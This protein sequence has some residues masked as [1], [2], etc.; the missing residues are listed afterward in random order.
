M[1]KKSV[2]IRSEMKQATDWE[3]QQL[4]EQEQEALCPSDWVEHQL[5][6]QENPYPQPP[7]EIDVESLREF[8]MS[9]IWEHYTVGKQGQ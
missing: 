8:N 1:R 2:Q 3:E 6:L 5:Y 7:D 9:E 4:R